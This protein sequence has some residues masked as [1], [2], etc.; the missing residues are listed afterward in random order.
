MKKM[1]CLGLTFVLLVSALA[2]V[3]A[4]T[5]KYGS[6]GETVRLVQTKLKDLG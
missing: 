5:V 1:I 2:A 6:T 3:S 4:E